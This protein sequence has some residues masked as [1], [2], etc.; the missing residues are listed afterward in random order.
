[1]LFKRVGLL[2]RHEVGLVDDELR[3]RLRLLDDGVEEVEPVLEMLRVYHADVAREAVVVVQH[4]V[5]EVFFHIGR[6]GDA[7]RLDEQHR[8]P[9]VFQNRVKPAQEVAFRAGA[10]YRAAA[11]LD[12]FKAVFA[13]HVAVDAGLAEFVH[14]HRDALVLRVRFKQVFQKRRLAA[15]QKSRQKINLAF[16]LVHWLFV[17]SVR[18]FK[19]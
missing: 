17:P 10:E 1:M 14:Q 13:H 4:P 5:A 2:L 8:R 9:V 6:V 7:A 3:R 18:F 16:I 11:Y 15:S 19:D 12:Y